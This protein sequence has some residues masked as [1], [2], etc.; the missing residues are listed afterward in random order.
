MSVRWLVEVPQAREAPEHIRQGLRD[1]DPTAEVIYL[2]P[3]QW[4]VGKVRPNVHS[5]RIAV[6][7]LDT[8]TSQLST[9]QRLSPRGQ[10]RARFALLALQGFRPVEEYRM[11]DLDWRVVEDFR[12]SQWKMRHTNPDALLDD[13]ER[14]EEAR[15]AAARAEIADEYRAA[16]A[17]RFLTTS[18]FGYASPSVAKPTHATPGRVRHTIPQLL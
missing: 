15:K 7:L 2:G 16:E 8:F 5:R 18:N 3:M 4:L 13:M 6:T 9:G 1:L 12:V 10:R 14:A 11:R 17:H